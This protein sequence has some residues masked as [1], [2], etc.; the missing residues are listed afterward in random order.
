MAIDVLL[1]GTVVSEM[2]SDSRN[3]VQHGRITLEARDA[4][5]RRIHVVCS[6]ANERLAANLGAL[7]QG[8]SACVRGHAIVPFN[9]LKMDRRPR[10]NVHVTDVLE[11]N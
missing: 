1:M 11:L 3:G 10:L 9:L 8:Q 6:T 7:K 5:G 2:Q 4:I